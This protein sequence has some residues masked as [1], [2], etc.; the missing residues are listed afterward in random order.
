MTAVEFVTVLLITL[1]LIVL[2]FT[3]GLKLAG[4]YHRT[5]TQEREYALQKQYVRLIANADAD[6]P[7]GP[8]VPRQKVQLPPEFEERFRENGRA[9]VSLNPNS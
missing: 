2:S 7:V 1:G 6:D 9:T 8:Y 3:A 4:Y 5:A